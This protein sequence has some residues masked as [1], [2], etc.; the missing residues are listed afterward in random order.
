MVTA[1]DNHAPRGAAT[2][3]LVSDPVLTG[4][5]PGCCRTKAAADSPAS[6]SMFRSD[7]QTRDDD[8]AGLRC[9]LVDELATFAGSSATARRAHTPDQLSA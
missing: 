2:G 5:P 7:E 9:E 4:T 8:V 6:W 1:V 3:A